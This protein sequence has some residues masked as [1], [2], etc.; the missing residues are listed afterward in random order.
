MC[1]VSQFCQI[2]TAYLLPQSR[3]RNVIPQIPACFPLYLTSASLTRAWHSLIYLP[4]WF[5]LSRMAYKWNHKVC[6][7][8]VW[9]LSL[10]LM[11]LKVFRVVACISSPFLFITVQY[12]IRREALTWWWINNVSNMRLASLSLWIAVVSSSLCIKVICGKISFKSSNI[13]GLILW[14]SCSG[15]HGENRS[16]A[17]V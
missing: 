6:S 4:L 3:Y 7:P 9:L 2:H 16:W 5:C 13:Q 12:S 17:F 11:H 15:G 1:I 10:G 14:D 8:W